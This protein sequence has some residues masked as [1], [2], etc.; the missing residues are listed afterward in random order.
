MV[1]TFDKKAATY[2]NTNL[3]KRHN[4][5]RPLRNA[6]FKRAQIRRMGYPVSKNL[7]RTCINPEK[8]NLGM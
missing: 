6:K 7:W 3:K 8:R 4:L 5:M 1:L 2:E